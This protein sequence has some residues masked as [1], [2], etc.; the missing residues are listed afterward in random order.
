MVG[1]AAK[2]S[3]V[4]AHFD[5]IASSVAQSSEFSQTHIGIILSHFAINGDKIEDD[6]TCYGLWFGHDSIFFCFVVVLAPMSIAL[7]LCS[8]ID[9]DARNQSR[10]IFAMVSMLIDLGHA[11]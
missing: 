5:Q 1:G 8:P 4:P 10:F 3:V 9:S 11:A 2:G 6:P 7:Y